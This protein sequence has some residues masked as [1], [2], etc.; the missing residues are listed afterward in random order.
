VGLVSF[1]GAGGV[2]FVILYCVKMKNRVRNVCLVCKYWA[3]LL[4]RKHGSSVEWR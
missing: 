3:E 2:L 4:Y 1:V